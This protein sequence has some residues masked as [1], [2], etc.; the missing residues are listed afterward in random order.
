MM[1]DLNSDEHNM[2]KLKERTSRE[3]EK[4]KSSK[5]RSSSKKKHREVT[6]SDDGDDQGLLPIVNLSSNGNEY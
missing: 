1:L 3:G 4:I 6:S 2:R 5:Y